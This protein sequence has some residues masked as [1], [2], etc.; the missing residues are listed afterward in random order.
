M[1]A[2]KRKSSG[3]DEGRTAGGN[4]IGLLLHTGGPL[5]DPCTSEAR[6]DAHALEM[7]GSN[8]AVV[9]YGGHMPIRS[10]AFGCHY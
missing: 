6:I 10:V 9:A 7:M 1:V 5:V 4:L 2:K 3:D 8:C